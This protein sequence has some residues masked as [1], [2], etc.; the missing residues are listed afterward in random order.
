[1][2]YF[3]QIILSVIVFTIGSSCSR[4]IIIKESQLTND[5]FYLPEEK[6]PYTGECLIY[7]PQTKIPHYKFNYKDGIMDGPYER[8]F[9]N[10]RVE[11]SGNYKVGNLEGLWTRYDE[12]GKIQFSGFY[13]NGLLTNVKR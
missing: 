5:I 12:N 4:S 1:M 9:R 7:Y 10:G 13:E 3:F 8:Y 2:K 6:D 11:F